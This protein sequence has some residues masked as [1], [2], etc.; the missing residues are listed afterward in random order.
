MKRICVIGLG[1]IGLPTASL[2]ANNGFDVLGVDTNPDIVG[3]INSSDIHIE[4]V[5]LRTLVEAAVGSGYLR[6]STHPDAADAFVIAVPTPFDSQKKPDLSFVFRATEAIMPHLRPGDLVIVES[7][8]PP[9]TTLRL[10]SFISERRPDLAKHEDPSASSLQVYVAHCP[11]RV[12]P[13]QILKEL[14][15]NDRV[16]GG[17]TPEAAQRAA[18]LYGAIVSGKIYET[19]ATTAEMVKLS[20]NTFRDVNI[21][22]ANELALLCQEL[23]V[24]VWE[25]IALANRHPRVKI[26]NPGPGV[27][28]HCI[29]VDPWFLVS[30]FPNETQVIQAA[31]RRNDSMPGIVVKKL[32]Q[33]VE[34]EEHPKIACLGASYKG[35]TGDPRNSPAIE[36]Y[37]ALCAHFG[38]E[39]TVDLSD[40]YVVDTK[41]PLRPLEDAVKGASLIVIL[42]DHE[43]YK[44][45]DP[46]E[47]AKHVRRKVVFDARNILNHSK[48][49]EAGFEVHVLGKGFGS[50]EHRE[51][52]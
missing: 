1:Y 41:Y 20:E 23:G 46:F 18:G 15:D 49:Q 25:V 9:G 39:G 4:E 38:K 29:A 8:V 52:E 28:G 50:Q 10:A 5:G 2:F 48:W 27:G 30:E 13:G 45:L 47:I 12:L 35:N 17:V 33:A 31:R 51:E 22:L 3:T 37:E 16:I 7:T 11:E 24:D 42:T 34:K 21:S 40:D 43:E 19:D 32:L 44:S 26:L 36:I 6:A 14:V